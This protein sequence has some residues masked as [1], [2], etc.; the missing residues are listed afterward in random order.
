[1]GSLRLVVAAVQQ[2]LAK[3]SSILLVDEL[4]HGLEPHRVIRLLDTL[5]AKEELPPSQVFLTT[6]SPVAIR[7]LNSDALFILREETGGNHACIPVG[8]ADRVQGT[9][10]RYPE[11]LLSRGIIVCEGASEVGLL[12]GLDHH[13]HDEGRPNLASLG[14]MAVDGGGHTEVVGRASAFQSLGFQTAILR[15]GDLGVPAGE[16]E[17]VTNGGRVFSWQAPHALEDELFAAMPEGAVHRVLELAIE[18]VG[19]PTADANIKSA[20]NGRLGLEDCRG[21]LSTEHRQALGRAAKAKK[22]TWF[23][24]VSEMEKVGREVVAPVL[25]SSETSFRRVLDSVRR[26]AYDVVG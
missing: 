23:K 9:V 16:S 8:S 10:R 22:G 1:M 6:H 26:W 13:D 11:A 17:Y 20:S 3:S 25:S 21:Q 4:E 18:K 5:G 2:R 7:E 15:D 12:R 19:E 14:I 24:S